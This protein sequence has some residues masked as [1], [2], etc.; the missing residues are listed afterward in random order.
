MEQDQYKKLK[1]VWNSVKYRC[2][3]PS[4]P[5]YAN[6]GGKGIT[7]S[8]A[9]SRLWDFITYV[10]NNLPPK[11]DKAVLGRIDLSKG[12]EPGNICWSTRAASSQ[13][14]E[15]HIRKKQCSSKYIGVTIDKKGGSKPYKAQ[16]SFEGK[17]LHLGYF[18]NE[19]VAAK[20]RD[21]KAKELNRKHGAQFRLNFL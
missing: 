8:P 14:A 19:V 5:Q 1:Y 9:F 16:I 10:E 11:P 17:V 12:Y 21:E 18:S 3:S 7:F 4:H 2:V 15:K 6:Y 20:A 13:R